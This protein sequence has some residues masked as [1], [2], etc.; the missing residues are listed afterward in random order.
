MIGNMEE[1]AHAYKFLA[2][3]HL[4]MNNVEEAYIAAQKSTEFN[5]VLLYFIYLL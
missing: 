5:E 1:Q 3:N 4:K 2:N